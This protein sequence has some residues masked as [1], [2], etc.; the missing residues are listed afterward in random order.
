MRHLIIILLLLSC[1]NKPDNVKSF[2][3]YLGKDKAESLNLAIKAWDDFVS[4]NR[5]TKSSTEF[6]LHFLQTLMVSW[7]SLDKWKVDCKQFTA[8]IDE[9]KRTDFEKEFW[10]YTNETYDDMEVIQYYVDVI[11]K[12]YTN[13]PFDT[14]KHN[15]DFE[16][17]LEVPETEGKPTEDYEPQIRRLSS[18]HSKIISGIHKYSDDDFVREGAEITIE[19]GHLSPTIIIGG[20]LENKKRVDFSNYFTKAFI[21]QTI[22]YD[23]IYSNTCENR[24]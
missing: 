14:I 5:G 21:I 11:N 12:N 19:V 23:F 6:S 15:D 8:V 17:I 7:D 24:R 10:M 18:L 1:N 3:N 22:F 9:I 20:I 13:E 16:E 4:N 2:E